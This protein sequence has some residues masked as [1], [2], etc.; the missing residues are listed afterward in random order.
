MM[1][2]ICSPAFCI[3]IRHWCHHSC[4][5]TYSAPDLSLGMGLLAHQWTSLNGSHHS[6]CLKPTITAWNKKL[7]K[8]VCGMGGSVGWN[9]NICVRVCVCV[10]ITRLST[11]VYVFPLVAPLLMNCQ[12][13]PRPRS[14]HDAHSP[15]RSIQNVKCDGCS[16]HKMSD[17]WPFM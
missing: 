12:Q 3:N 10:C 17:P 1:V 16:L 15:Q 2:F 7:F 5:S 13:L 6:Q 9:G 4:G 14:Y 11:C 8:C